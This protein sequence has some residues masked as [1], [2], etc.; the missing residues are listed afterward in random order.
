LEAGATFETNPFEKVPIPAEA[1]CGFR[2]MSDQAAQL[3]DLVMLSL[4]YGIF[5]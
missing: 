4:F 1:L 2:E 5:G 3:M